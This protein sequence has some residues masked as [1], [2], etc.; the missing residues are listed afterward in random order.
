MQQMDWIRIILFAQNDCSFCTWTCTL[1]F[2]FSTPTFVEVIFRESVSVETVDSGSA[3]FTSAQFYNTLPL[4]L[5]KLVHMLWL[6]QER[7]Q[8]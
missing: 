2:F 7:R 6:A 4:Q 1:F 5:R 3:D 8:M